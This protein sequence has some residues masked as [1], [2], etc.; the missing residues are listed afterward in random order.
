MSK[1]HSDHTSEP[2][3]PPTHAKVRTRVG[4]PQADLRR[5]YIAACKANWP[6]SIDYASFVD[7][8][9]G[10]RGKRTGKPC[11]QKGLFANGR[12]RWHGGLSSGP[13]TPEG[14]ARS[15][16]NG[17]VPKGVSAVRSEPHE[18][19]KVYKR[20]QASRSVNLNI[21]AAVQ[22]LANAMQP[23]TPYPPLGPPA[24]PRPLATIRACLAQRPGRPLTTERLA[25][26]TGLSLCTTHAALKLLVVMKQVTRSSAGNK[27]SV[28]YAL[29]EQTGH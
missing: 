25:S 1:R 5:C 14:K 6:P 26:L 7:L 15:S 21:C 29:A 10:A 4:D 11:L 23:R 2:Y 19:G 22:P 8:I 28:V 13:K 20:V 9:C 16:L 18:G 12:C 27:Q 17:R 24:Q 3:E